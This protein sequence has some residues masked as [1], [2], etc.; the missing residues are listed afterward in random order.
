MDTSKRKQILITSFALLS[1]GHCSH[2]RIKLR[3][4]RASTHKERSR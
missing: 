4:P 2:G 1:V 3:V